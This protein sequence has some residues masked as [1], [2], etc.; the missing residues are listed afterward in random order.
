MFLYIHRRGAGAEPERGWIV[1]R[2]AWLRAG[3]LIFYMSTEDIV[4]LTLC[5]ILFTLI[6]LALSGVLDEGSDKSKS[7]AEKGDALFTEAC[8]NQE[9][10]GSP[11]ES[12]V[13]IKKNTHAHR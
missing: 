7:V 8:V 11:P 9:N 5:I 1:D 6:C 10:S 2:F 3:V 4:R 13:W 12:G